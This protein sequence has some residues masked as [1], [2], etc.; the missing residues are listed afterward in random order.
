MRLS[1]AQSFLQMAFL[2]SAFLPDAEEQHLIYRGTVPCELI[3]VQSD[4]YLKESDII[5]FKDNIKN[6]LDAI[7]NLFWCRIK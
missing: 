6:L 1:D 4:E 5:R 2:Q 3:K 7:I